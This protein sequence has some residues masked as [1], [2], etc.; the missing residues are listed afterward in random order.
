MLGLCVNVGLVCIC[1][2]NRWEVEQRGFILQY[3]TRISWM[4]DRVGKLNPCSDV[5]YFGHQI[6]KIR[7]YIYIGQ[8]LFSSCATQPIHQQVAFL[9][10]SLKHIYKRVFDIRIVIF[11]TNLLFLDFLKS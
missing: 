2:V 5:G 3:H 4:R 10:F 1:W 8:F 9:K 11:E 6:Y 7:I